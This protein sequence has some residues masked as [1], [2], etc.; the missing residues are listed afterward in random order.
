M[1]AK[2]EAECGALLSVGRAGDGAASAQR[3]L[4]RAV[5]VVPLR[6]VLVPLF[7]RPGT[8]SP[9]PARLPRRA[10]KPGKL[11]R[12]STLQPMAAGYTLRE[13]ME[14][15]GHSSLSAT[16]RYVKLR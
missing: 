13:I 4:T 10:A 14:Y 5:T 3:R 7:T 11:E 9:E 15:L 16:E 8:T 1:T 6:V 12:M 2:H